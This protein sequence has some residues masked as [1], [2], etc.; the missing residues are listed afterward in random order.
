[1]SGPRDNFAK[2]K[3]FKD[4]GND[5]FKKGD[6]KA[7]LKAYNFA[8]L[9]LAGLDNAAVSAFVSRDSGNN[10]GAEPLTQTEKDEIADTIKACHANMAA[11]YLKTGNN[12]KAID[13]CEK[14]IKV[15]ENNAKARQALFQMRELDKAQECL[16]SA[17]KMSPNDKGIREL[18]D[19]V[20]G[21]IADLEAKS[22]AELRANLKM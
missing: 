4:E 1:M 20:K 16:V 3:A 5:H 12:Q 14:V 9:H 15:D 10:G 2:G 19:K 8:L 11:C 18:L 13:F 22:R 6:I 21:T 17:V 7:A